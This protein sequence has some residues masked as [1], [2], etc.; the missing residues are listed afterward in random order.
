MIEIVAAFIAGICVGAFAFRG[1]SARS[2]VY[3]TVTRGPHEGTIIALAKAN[4]VGV[5]FEVDGEKVELPID[6]VRL[7]LE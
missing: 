2:T 4:F 3:A 1:S 6:D 5:S 7:S